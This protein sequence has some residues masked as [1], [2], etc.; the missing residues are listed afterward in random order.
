MRAG[1]SLRHSPTLFQEACSPGVCPALP[2]LCSSRTSFFPGFSGYFVPC[3]VGQPA[4]LPPHRLAPRAVSL[5]CFRPHDVCHPVLAA[6]CLSVCLPSR[7]LSPRLSL[8]C[9]W[10][11][12][13]CSCTRSRGAGRGSSGSHCSHGGRLHTRPQGGKTGRPRMPQDVHTLALT[14]EDTG[15]YLG[16]LFTT[17]PG[18]WALP[19]TSESHLRTALHFALCAPGQPA[20]Q[21]WNL[22]HR[23]GDH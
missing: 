12:L 23:L 9:P 3:T 15:L 8:T 13:S 6:P 22:S 7:L 4:V 5:G 19:T 10:C 18:T 17:L 2:P 16:D 21:P 14:P 1:P 11:S 20:A